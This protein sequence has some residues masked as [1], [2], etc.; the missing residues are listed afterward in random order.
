M[1]MGR[2]L[3]LPRHVRSNAD[4]LNIYMRT[5]AGRVTEWVKGKRKTNEDVYEALDDT[6][7]VGI[8]KMNDRL[9]RKARQ[10]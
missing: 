2:W 6:R 10:F 3:F 7:E 4:N 5:C 1:P 8:D 9:R